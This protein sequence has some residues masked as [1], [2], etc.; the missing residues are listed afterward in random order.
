MNCSMHSGV[1]LLKQA[2]KIVGKVLDKRL[3]KIA[4]IDDMPFG[5]MSGKGTVDAVYILRRMR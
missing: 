4:T 2:M 5:F 1:K 3:I